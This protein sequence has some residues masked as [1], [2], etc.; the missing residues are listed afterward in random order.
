MV[1]NITAICTT[2][3]LLSDKVL[4]SMKEVFFAVLHESQK[5]FVSLRAEE[6]TAIETIVAIEDIGAIEAI[7]AIGAIAAIA[8]YNIYDNY[9]KEKS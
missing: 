1:H 2:V 7:E 8:I 3:P 9:K 5:K 4:F 6:A